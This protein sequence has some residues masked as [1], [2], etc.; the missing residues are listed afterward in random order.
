MQLNS[1]RE[2][3]QKVDFISIVNHMVAR[4]GFDE[5]WLDD[6]EF[7]AQQLEDSGIKDLDPRKVMRDAR[8]FRGLESL[9]KALDNLETIASFAQIDAE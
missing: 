6:V 5:A 4:E 1:A 2:L 9:V 8:V 3:M 7:W